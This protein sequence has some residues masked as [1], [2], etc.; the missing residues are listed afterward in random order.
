MTTTSSKSGVDDTVSVVETPEI[1]NVS[2]IEASLSGD[3]VTTM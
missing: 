1:T 3:T 2:T